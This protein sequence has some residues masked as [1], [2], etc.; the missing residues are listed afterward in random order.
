MRLP[1]C[2]SPLLL[3]LAGAAAAQTSPWYVGAS[4]SVTHESNVYRL[5]DGAPPPPGISKSDLI[6]STSLLAGLDQAFGRQRAY[7]TATL[8]SSRFQ[9]NGVLD[10]EGYAL[11]AGL[12]WSTA[13]RLSGNLD[14]RADRSLAR[15][16]TDTEI[17]LLTRQ[18]VEHTRQI[19]AAV[20][21]GVVTEYTAEAT[22]EH[23]TVDYSAPEY[24]ER[25][26]R[27]TAVTLGLRWR[28]SGGT[29]LGAGLRHVKG[30]YPRFQPLPGG[31]F[32]ADRYTRNGL[33]LTGGLDL[34]GASRIEARATI[35]R[36]R[37]EQAEQRGFSGVT[38]SLSWDWRPTAKL[39]LLSRLSRDSGQDSSYSGDPFVDGVIDYSRTTTALTLRAD[40]AATAKIRLNLG[41]NLARRDLVRTLPP[42]ALFPADASGRENLTELSLGLTWEPTRSLVFGCDA[43][44]ERRSVS[45]T[46]SLPYTAGRFGCYGQVFLR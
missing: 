23:R 27:Q 6:A 28:P 46:L 13:E 7:G 33:D 22:L 37:Y 29:V 31:G 34:S 32:Q 43:G 30:E 2:L 14:L 20:R 24:D 17:G 35:G 44:H 42:D 8:R 1:L 36:T 4:Q 38:G 45:G 25:E 26:N 15:F 41:L 12:D 11:R 40:Y 16:N 19:A 5:P 39:R 9:D 10:N 3:L 21:L 18:N